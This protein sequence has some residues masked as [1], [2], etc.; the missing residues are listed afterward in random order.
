MALV[1]PRRIRFSLPVVNGLVIIGSV[2]LCSMLLLMRLPGMELAGVGPHWFLIW[3]VAWSV[4]RSPVQGILAGITLGLIQDGLTA[5]APIHGVSLALVGYLTARIQKQRFVEEDFISIALI[6]FGMAI[7]NETAIA[8]QLCI[9]LLHNQGIFSLLPDLTSTPTLDRI[10][11]SDEL[12]EGRRT[13][14]EV[15]VY[16]QRA[17]LSS[18]IVSSLWAPVLYYPLNRWW[19]HFETQNSQS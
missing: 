15:W 3:V 12:Q 13:L 9:P 6:V 7:I 8:I 2:L 1:F 18:A 11:T 19:Q 17:A 14:E 5:T 16:H 10:L 4:K